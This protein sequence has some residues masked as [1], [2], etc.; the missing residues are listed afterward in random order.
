MPLTIKAKGRP[1][2]DFELYSLFEDVSKRWNSFDSNLKT[3]PT[4]FRVLLLSIRKLRKKLKNLWSL[5]SDKVWLC[6][7]RLGR[8]GRFL[9]SSWNS[10]QV[11]WD[12]FL[13]T[14]CR[15][16]QRIWQHC[17]RFSR[18][19]SC[20]TSSKISYQHSNCSPTKTEKCVYWFYY[21]LPSGWKG[22]QLAD[23]VVR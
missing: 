13:M 17:E 10:S 1:F 6:Q 19:F 2:I 12:S 9:I 20:K 4:N 14:F 15:A 18:L 22:T 8:L 11:G 5:S 3:K 23:L 21:V 7:Q 16:V